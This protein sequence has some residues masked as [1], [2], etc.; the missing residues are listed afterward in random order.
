MLSMT[1]ASLGWA[2]WWIVLF[3]HKL[4]P[5]VAF[6]IGLPA[7][8]STVFAVLG[9]GVAIL[10]FR[11]RRSWMLFVTVPLVA[12]ASLLLVPWLAGEAWAGAQAP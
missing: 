7:T 12:N 5:E 6:G 4:A 2:T 8:I 10:T 9:L 11:A 3:V 1:L